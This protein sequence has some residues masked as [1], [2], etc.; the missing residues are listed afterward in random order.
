MSAANVLTLTT[1]NFKQEV[2]NSAT[3]V[4]VDFWAEWCGPCKFLAPTIDELAAEYG[5]K[6]KFGKVN[7]DN[8][9]DLAVQYNIHSIPTILF[10][11]GG[12]VVNQ[13][14]GMAPKKKLKDALDRLL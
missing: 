2:L 8:D 4:L 11:K 12:Q 7:I 14:V 13:N 3:P 9:Q 10:F 5:D 1:A 6:V